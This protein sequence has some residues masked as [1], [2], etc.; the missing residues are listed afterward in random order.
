MIV[1]SIKKQKVF[2]NVV[3]ILSQNEYKDVLLNSKSFRQ[4]MNRIQSTDHG[5]GT[6]EINKKIL[7]CFDEKN[8]HPKQ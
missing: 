1:V 7:S 6:Y 3:A 8:I 5:I 4:T 2:K